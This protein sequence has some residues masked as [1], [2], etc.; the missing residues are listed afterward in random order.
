MLILRDALY[1][2]QRF[3]DFA[4]HLDIPRAVLTERL[5]ALV[6]RGLL[7]RL[8]DPDHGGRALYRPTAEA[9]N[10][11]PALHALMRWGTEEFGDGRPA[12]IHRHVTC[13]S[14]LQAGGSCP[15]CDTVAPLD[16]VE[17]E[18]VAS[19]A[20]RTDPVSV[21]LRGPRR[22]LLPLTSAETV[23]AAPPTG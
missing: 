18:R 7:E 17:S 10:L 21:A 2:V 1:G 23:A 5:R 12:R 4:V 8:P 22:M 19:P 6:D 16:E 3:N 11:W 15:V 14:E 13:G 9:R 20:S